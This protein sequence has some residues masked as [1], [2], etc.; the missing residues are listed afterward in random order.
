MTPI[1]LHDNVFRYATPTVTDEATGYEKAYLTDGRAYTKWKGNST[2]IKYITVD[3][4][5]TDTVSLANTRLSLMSGVAFV[6]LIGVDLGAHVGKRLTL[7]DSGGKTATGWLK[8][9]GSGVTYGSNL[10]SGGDMPADIGTYWDTVDAT[11]ASVAGGHAG[12]CMELTRTGGTFQQAL[13]GIANQA[14]G[15]CYELTAYL[16][17]GTAGDEDAYLGFYDNGADHLINGYVLRSF[18]SSGT[19]AGC[20]LTG[21]PRSGQVLG[22]VFLHKNSS[23]AGTMLFDTVSLRQILT[24]SHTGATIVS[25][26][27]GATR[28]WESEETGFNRND[29]AGYT[30]TIAAAA[31]AVAMIGHN[32]ASE[33]IL[34][35]VES[36]DNNTDWTERLAPTWASSNRAQCAVF[37]QATA[38]YWRVKL[39]AGT[40][41]PSIGELI[42]GP[43]LAFEFP[44]DAPYIPFTEK[45]VATSATG[46]TGNLLGSV[47]QFIALDLSA[48]FS[49]VSRVWALETF[50][51]FWDDHA[52]RLLPFFW[53]WDLTTFPTH[54]FFVRMDAGASQAMPLSIS[55]MVDSLVL[56]MQGVKEA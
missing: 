8:A 16:K 38:R 32:L 4:G 12:N 46:K 15:A 18:T 20:S 44:A 3:A 55:T 51:P 9:A 43:R 48:R 26:R 53:A 1:I 37:T 19:W 24:P 40:A 6:D 54:V 30:L 47:V 13:Q 29:A 5:L 22:E 41:A 14:A 35:S 42:L 21:T 39:A 2:G 7:T 49:H 33:E 10:L 23:T 50:L 28:A 52:S 56:S 17:S 36:S 34:Y 25:T 31:D 11:I 45:V 27:G